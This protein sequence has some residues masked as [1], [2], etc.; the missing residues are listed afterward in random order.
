MKLKWLKGKSS[1]GEYY[2]Y[3]PA[4]KTVYDVIGPGDREATPAEVVEYL[5]RPGKN[6]AHN[7]ETR[8][9]YEYIREDE[10]LADSTLPAGTYF[11][12]RG[13]F[14]LP[15]RLT[16]FSLRSDSATSLDPLYELQKEVDFFLDSRETYKK[17]GIQFRRGILM[18]GPPGEGKTTIIR[19]LASST[20]PEDSITL[21]TRNMP[22][23][24]MLNHIKDTESGRLKIFVFEELAAVIDERYGRVDSMLDFLDGETSLDNTLIIATTN[25]P[26][27]LPMNIIDRPSRFDI[28]LKVGH[29]SKNEAKKLVKHYLGEWPGC[30]DDADL[31]NL[32]TAAIKEAC[33]QVLIKGIDFSQAV[34]KVKS[35]HEIA[36]ADFSDTA[37]ES[38]TDDDDDDDFSS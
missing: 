38:G 10:E 25:Y 29:P 28:L 23:V 4:E 9:G 24:S 33:L 26:E 18:Y 13:G 30:A 21:F 14:H 11:Y 12:R 19:Q 8:V 20:F 1:E 15:E 2:T 35:H 5:E 37:D 16:S 34:D 7:L 6:T 31:S 36:T 3:T 22:S 27:R 17:V 32:S